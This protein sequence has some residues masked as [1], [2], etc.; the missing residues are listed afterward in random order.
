[1]SGLAVSG[2]VLETAAVHRPALDCD[3]R[4]ALVSGP[5]ENWWNCRL[6]HGDTRFL[7]DFL[8]YAIC[9]QVGLTEVPMIDRASV[10]EGRMIPCLPKSDIWVKS[11][12]NMRVCAGKSCSSLVRK[13][14]I[15]LSG[16]RRRR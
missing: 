5:H 16:C 7:S 9:V 3:W 1:M 6:E 2:L 11:R 15:R 12:A 8:A 10:A 4:L 14:R 13:L